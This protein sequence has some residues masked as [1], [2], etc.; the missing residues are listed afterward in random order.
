MAEHRAAIT[1]A[2]GPDIPMRIFKREGSMTQYIG[3]WGAW[4]GDDNSVRGLKVILATAVSAGASDGVPLAEVPWV[5]LQLQAADQ[6]DQVFDKLLGALQGDV[7]KRMATETRSAR[8]CPGKIVFDSTQEVHSV[9][10]LRNPEAL[11]EYTVAR[12]EEATPGARPANSL[13]RERIEFQVFRGRQPDLR[14]Q[15]LRVFVERKLPKPQIVGQR[16]RSE[17][18]F[19]RVSDLLSAVGEW[20]TWILLGS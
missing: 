20:R 9:R 1:R 13:Q 16:L 3:L 4:W 6:S 14:L 7:D 11:E 10:S 2:L 19:A 12:S 5:V 15:T 8:R 17:S 18:G